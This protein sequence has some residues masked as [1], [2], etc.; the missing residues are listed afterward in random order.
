MLSEF[1]QD[2]LATRDAMSSD[3]PVEVWSI[4]GE[5]QVKRTDEV[6]CTDCLRLLVREQA[7]TSGAKELAEAALE[8]VRRQPTEAWAAAA[9]RVVKCFRATFAN[10]DR[11]CVSETQFFWRFVTEADLHTLFT[12]LTDVLMPNPFERNGVSSLLLEHT[13]R[14]AASLRKLRLEWHDPCSDAMVARGVEAH[15]LNRQFAD[16]LSSQSVSCQPTAPKRGGKQ[17]GSDNMFSLQELPQVFASKEAL[18]AFVGTAGTARAQPQTNTATLAAASI[19]RRTDPTS[20]EFA[21]A[22]ALRRVAAFQNQVASAPGAHGVPFESSA[23][24]SPAPVQPQP[25]LPAYPP[26]DAP[27][28]TIVSHLRTHNLCF[29]RAFSGRC[30]RASC[31][32][33]H[34]TVPACFY[35]SVSRERRG[36]PPRQIVESLTEAQYEFAALMG[37]VDDTDRGT[38]EASTNGASA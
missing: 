2:H 32:Y 27:R 11:P 25:P 38:F 23:R 22:P 3:E 35:N 19:D 18:A 21:L 16:I 12:R 26:A 13:Q 28:D 24:S 15:R 37:L 9:A 17:V 1:A 4:T 20:P 34:D 36:A 10:A 29:A 6:T 31:R 14:I 5:V 30:N 33:S 7:L 8:A